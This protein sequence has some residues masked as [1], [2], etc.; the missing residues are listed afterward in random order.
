M[1]TKIQKWGNSFGVRLPMEIIR[2]NG[3]SNGA[4][5]KI[6]KAKNKIIIEYIPQ[7]KKN[8]LSDLLSQ[9]KSDNLHVE[10]DWGDSQGQE[11]W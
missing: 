2:E 1:T 6:S 9:I 4:P 5:V 11:I 8:N 10:S 7:T 3:L